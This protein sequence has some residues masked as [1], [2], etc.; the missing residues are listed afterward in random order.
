MNYQQNL[1]ICSQRFS[2]LEFY[3]RKSAF[4]NIFLI[5]S[6]L[7]NAAYGTIPMTV[8]SL[9]ISQFSFLILTMIIEAIT[10]IMS[11]SFTNMSTEVMTITLF[12]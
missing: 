6:L 10:K 7:V 1:R 2:L 3:L 8:L 4:K 9:F 12:M 5:C 11:M